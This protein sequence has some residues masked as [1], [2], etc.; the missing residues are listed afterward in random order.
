MRGR[1]VGGAARVDTDDVSPAWTAQLRAGP[2]GCHQVR[3]RS[4]RRRRQRGQP[5]IGMVVIAT[6][7]L[8]ASCSTS[9]AT[10][11]HTAA[12]GPRGAATGRVV[13]TTIDGA[14]VRVPG[15]RPSVLVFLSMTC[16][17]CAD[18]ARSLAQ[19]EAATKA[20]ARAAHLATAKAR[21]LGVDMDRG[22]SGQAVTDFLH[23]VG[24]AGLP[25]VLDQKAVLSGAYQVTALSTVLVIDPAG[26]VTFR[27][28]NPSPAKILA[29]VDAVS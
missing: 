12:S 26:R 7:V 10:R 28:I 5:L 17:D 20:T 22:A 23:S 21:F 16:A 24:A 6:A 27:A 4:G 15:N 25:T 8:L 1:L 29:A 3:R 14:A 9:P 18:A 11:A 13:L 2:F 19:V